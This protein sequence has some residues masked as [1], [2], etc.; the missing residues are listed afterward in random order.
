MINNII[1]AVCNLLGEN[2]ENV[3]IYDEIVKQGFETPCFCVNAKSVEDCLFRGERYY[4]KGEIEIRFYGAEYIKT[5]GSNVMERL[6]NILEIID[7]ENIGMIRGSN[8]KNEFCNDYFL[9]CVDYEFFYVRKQQ[10]ELMGKVKLEME[11]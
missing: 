3:R 2:F 10:T 9:F 4:F 11:I 1:R 7:A 5:N 6:W 8:M